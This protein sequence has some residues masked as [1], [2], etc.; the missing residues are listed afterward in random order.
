M[1]ERPVSAA[2]IVR[3]SHVLLVQRRATEGDLVW[4]F[5]AS[6]VEAGEPAEQ[7]AVREF[8]EETG[9]TVEALRLLG[10]RVH[11]KTGHASIF[12]AKDATHSSKQARAPARAIR[13]LSLFTVASEPARHPRSHHQQDGTELMPR[14]TSARKRPDSGR[15][16]REQELNRDTK[17]D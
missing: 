6:K 15:G 10:E 7:A 12:T 8:L 2:V 9:L 13:A 16:H 11:P 4:Q 5:P 17:P 3:G 1:T 14:V